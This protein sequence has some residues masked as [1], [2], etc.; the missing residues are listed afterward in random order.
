MLLIVT[1]LTLTVGL[2]A[3]P[4]AS[5][6]PPRVASLLPWVADALDRVGPPGVVVAVTR[7][8]LHQA[9]APPR[10][11]LGSPHAPNLERLAEARPTLIVGDRALHGPLVER[12]ERL[13]AEVFLVAA[14]TVDETFDSLLAL[15]RRVGSAGAMVR[16]IDAARG[17]L[18]ALRLGQ[19][20][21]VLVLFG[22]PGGFL[23]V[24]GRSWLGDLVE[25]IGFGN[26][27][28]AGVGAERHPG[29]VELADE[30]LAGLSPDLVLLVTHGDPT[31]IRAAFTERVATGPLHR[32]G[33][34]PRGVHVLSPVLFA[35]NPG[36]AMPEA[37]RAIH[38]LA[39][40]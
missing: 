2:P 15:A 28:T 1:M 16:E 37:A 25:R 39:V 17:D 24:T 13:G 20:M 21:P 10:I 3:A 31:R 7:R 29:Y 33:Q 32:L 35:S 8:D 26:V 11:D 5:A 4:A 14:T 30:I 12:L 36:L 9:P 38:D 18:R 23:V 6:K 19:P 34:A 27:A 22:T 40:P